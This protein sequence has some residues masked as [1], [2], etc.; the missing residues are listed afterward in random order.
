MS[1]NTPQFRATLLLISSIILSASGQIFMKL[2]MLDLHEIA[3]PNGADNLSDILS[4]MPALTW[5]GIGIGSY[6][7]SLL[8][9]LGVLARFELSFAYPM[10]SISY[11]LVYMVAVTWPR[12]GETTSPLKTAGIL[13]IIIGVILITH[14]RPNNRT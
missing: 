11:A 7:I 9:W 4:I 13:F 12:L 6:G 2:G 14:T 5:I 3:Y 1:H 8:A 10:L